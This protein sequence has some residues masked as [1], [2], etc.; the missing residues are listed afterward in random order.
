MFRDSPTWYWDVY[1]FPAVTR[2]SGIHRSERPKTFRGTTRVASPTRLWLSTP[3]LVAREDFFQ[4][5]CLYDVSGIDISPSLPPLRHDLN[6]KSFL[7]VEVSKT[8]DISLPVNDIVS[9]RNRIEP[10]RHPAT[11]IEMPRKGTVIT[12]QGYLC[13]CCARACTLVCVSASNGGDR[14]LAK[15]LF[16]QVHSGLSIVSLWSGVRASFPSNQR[17]F[18]L[19]LSFAR[20]SSMAKPGCREEFCRRS[21]ESWKL[22]RDMTN[23]N[24]WFIPVSSLP[25]W[26]LHAA[27]HNTLL[28]SVHTTG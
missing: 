12:S 13:A 7:R 3:R 16:Q 25:P 27:L 20:E 17:C 8:R 26:W 22:S 15:P 9:K 23:T 19:F 2:F 21:I 4:L 28:P 24:G 6:I 14:Q 18:S 1:T 11:L 5:G 10:R